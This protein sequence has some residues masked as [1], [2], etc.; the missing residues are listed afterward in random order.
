MGKK[1]VLVAVSLLA[2]QAFA[3]GTTA[4]TTATTSNSTATGTVPSQGTSTATVESAK[5]D[6]KKWSVSILTQSGVGMQDEKKLGSGAN[7]QTAGLLTMGFK[8]SDTTKINAGH[9]FLLINN[10]NALDADTQA[11]MSSKGYKEG[12][13]LMDPHLGVT[14]SK[15]SNGIFGS[16][17]ITLGL[18]YVIPVTK[19]ST[20]LERAGALRADSSIDWTINPKVTMSYILSPRIT[21][22]RTLEAGQIYRMIHYVGP[23]YSFNDNFGLYGIVGFDTAAGKTFNDFKVLRE[24]MELEVG[25]N[26]QVGSFYINPSISESVATNETMKVGVAEQASYNLILQAAF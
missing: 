21:L 12:Y 13:N 1:L 23:S 24:T 25:A 19:A 26:V 8:I 5:A 4:T 16:E 9:N 18:R 11:S 2:T 22:E 14:L 7:V 10:F 6:A 3:Q 15:F 17:P 20:D